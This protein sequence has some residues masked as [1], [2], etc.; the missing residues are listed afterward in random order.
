MTNSLRVAEDRGMSVPAGSI[1]RTGYVPV[2]NVML[3]CRDRMA[4]GD[5]ERAMQRRLGIAP[6]QPWPCPVGR[7]DGDRFIV[8]DGRHD[9]VGA[10]MLGVEHILVAWI[11]AAQSGET[12]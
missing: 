1:V 11:E 9:V 6:A 12:T 3:G 2:G 8:H 5:V 4:I 10:L 7:W